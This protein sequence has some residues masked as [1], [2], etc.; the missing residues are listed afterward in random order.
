MERLG[1]KWYSS[2]CEGLARAATNA[3][4]AKD[5]PDR[6]SSWEDWDGRDYWGEGEKGNAWIKNAEKY[7]DCGWKALKCPEQ[8]KNYDGI[9]F[10]DGVGCMYD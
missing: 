8:D 5:W 2:Q 9:E 6:W 7:Y 3:A 10:C 4:A 1:C